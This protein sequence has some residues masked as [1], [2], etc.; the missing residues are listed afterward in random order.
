MK[1]VKLVSP[2]AWPS[3]LS[4]VQMLPCGTDDPFTLSEGLGKRVKGT[5]C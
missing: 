5:S 1:A 3:N 4:T 2:P